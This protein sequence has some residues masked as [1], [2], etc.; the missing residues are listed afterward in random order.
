[1]PVTRRPG[2]S[3]STRSPRRSPSSDSSRRG[4]RSGAGWGRRYASDPSEGG[5][6][7]WGRLIYR[8]GVATRG[9]RRSSPL[10]V[11]K[12]LDGVEAGG[13]AGGVETEKDADGSGEAEGEKHC[14]HRDQRSPVREVADRV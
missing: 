1:M 13:F 11:P 8:E 9:F 14:V 5:S 10:L 6:T 3:T 4:R 2:R 7:T 12:G